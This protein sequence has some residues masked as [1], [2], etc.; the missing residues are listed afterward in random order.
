MDKVLL[1][2]ASGFVGRAVLEKIST[3]SVVLLAR[4]PVAGLKNKTIIK[5]IDE[6]VD[7]SDALDGINVVIHCAARV[8]VMK[9]DCSDPLEAYMKV[10]TRGTMA[11]AEQAAKSGVRRF[12]FISTIKVNGEETFDKP[13][14][15]A[16]K[17]QP[18]DD[19]GRSKSIAEEQLMALSEKTGMEVVIIRPPLVYGPKVKANFASLL[20]VVSKG[21]PLPFGCITNNKRS[22]VFIDNLVDLIVR[23]IEHPRAA[24]RVFLVSDGEDLSTRGLIEKMASGQTKKPLLLPIPVSLLNALGTI[25]GKASTIS[26]LTGSL[27]L[28]ISETCKLLTWQPPFKTEQAL[29]ATIKSFEHSKVK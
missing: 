9:D 6:H 11:L 7:F 26:R 23:T 29:T 3:H 20:K 27:Q 18:Q 16:D 15:A 28:D 4:K 22:I 13:F 17:R 24:N 25:T 2:G 10:N 14:T 8:H 1:T 12:I 5:D 19:Y 21:L